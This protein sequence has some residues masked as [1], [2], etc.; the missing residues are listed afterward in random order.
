M[1][2]EVHSMDVLPKICGN[3]EAVTSSGKPKYTR[4]VS[5]SFIKSIKNVVCSEGKNKF[6]TVLDDV[7]P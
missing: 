3:C 5:S 1:E 2:A 7:R 6:F 4:N